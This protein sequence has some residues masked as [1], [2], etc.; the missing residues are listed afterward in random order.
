[1]EAKSRKVK[2][3][4][5]FGVVGYLQ[6]GHLWKKLG[7]ALPSIDAALDSEDQRIDIAYLLFFVFRLADYSV[8]AR[9]LAKQWCHD[10]AKALDSN[11]FGGRLQSNVPL[12]SLPADI[13]VD[14]K[15]AVR[16]T[17]KFLLAA[18][19][20]SA[21]R[22]GSNRTADV[23]LQEVGR[24]HQCSFFSR[25]VVRVAPPTKQHGSLIDS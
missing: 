20:C 7:V 22:T 3:T 2:L 16:G 6:A 11:D 12:M 4:H 19:G 23:L 5:V 14:F 15:K 17:D 24:S 25:V 13:N 9:F 10:F 8:A 21:R 18:H 1:M